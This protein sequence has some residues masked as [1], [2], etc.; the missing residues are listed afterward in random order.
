L[1]LRESERERERERINA[2]KNLYCRLQY[3][4]SIAAGVGGRERI[5]EKERERESITVLIQ[6]ATTELVLPAIS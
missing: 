3:I 5:L 1:G 2:S 4:H 6:K